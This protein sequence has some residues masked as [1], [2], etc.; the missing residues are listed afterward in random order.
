MSLARHLQEA[1]M[2][3]HA[4]FCHNP[5]CS[6]HGQTGRGNI[7]IHSKK[8]RR[9]Y[10][11]LCKKPFAATRG[12]AFYRLQTDPETVALVLTLL[13]LGCPPQAI[14][15]AFGFDER[16]VARWLLATGQ[17]CECFHDYWTNEYPVEVQHAQ[18][19]ELW[20]KAVGRR[21]WMGMA[22]AVESRL[23][24]GGVIGAGRDRAFLRALI[25]IIR[26]AARHPAILICVDGLAGYVTAVR[27]VFRRPVYTGK[28][29]RP[30]LEAEKGVMVGQVIKQYAQGRVVA[31]TQQLVQG[32]ALALR[33]VLERTGGGTQINTAFIERLNATFRARLVLLV[34][35]GRALA[36][37]DAALWAG[38][39]LVGCAYNFCSF[40]ESLRLPAPKG[41]G[42]KWIERTPAMAAG[43]TE[44]RWSM[45]ELLSYPVP[46][47]R[48][49]AAPRRRPKAVPAPE[50][51]LAA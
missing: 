8:E 18:A 38:M 44:V 4:Q 47:E 10:C 24:L 31:V 6:A 29:G 11:K 13:S 26:R 25:Q 27:H 39:Y 42:R 51:A 21:L 14:V 23:W 12:T 17:H 1:R 50:L 2:N 7:G 45:R 40:H 5:A 46:P 37:T 16:T 22:I 30:R 35:R 49:E 28:P 41:A 33:R 20:I 32:S 19:D 3:P 34:R 15:A 48:K 43:L 9:F 36:H